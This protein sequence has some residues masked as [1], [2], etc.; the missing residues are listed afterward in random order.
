MYKIKLI[1]VILISLFVVFSSE[2]TAKTLRLSHHHAVGGQIDQASHIFADIVKDLTNGDLKIKIFPAAQLG[3]QNE[4]F[5]LLNKGVIDI[6]WTPLG[7]MDKYWPAIRVASLPF[8]FKGWDHFDDARSGGFGQAVIEG[9][10]ANSNSKILGIMGLGFRDMLF[11]E[12]PVRDVTKMK[13]LK[14]RA[15]EAFLWIRMFELLNAKPTPV[16][17]GEVY[18]AMQ[19][20]VA[21]G[22]EAPA[23]AALDMKF[24]EVIKS[25]VKTQHMFSHGAFVI[26][27]NTFAKLETKYKIAV[28]AAGREAAT[29]AQNYAR[30]ESEKAYDKM[31]AKGVSIY[32][33]INPSAWATAMKPLWDEIAVQHP[34]SP[35]IIYLLTK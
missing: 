17:W 16:T 34:D 13:G 33:P 4:A 3:Q 29:W 35:Q 2:I 30:S 12:N 18:T 25:L 5:E 1:V 11:R 10:E 32:D 21:A 28:S 14:M 31:I 8:I 9:V 23:L 27:K 7:L 20:G 22:L 26:N 19:T 15:P 24:N 6:T